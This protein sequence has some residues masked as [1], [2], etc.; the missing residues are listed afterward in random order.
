M[1][2]RKGQLEGSGEMNRE[3]GYRFILSVADKGTSFPMPKDNMCMIIWDPNG[4]LVYDNQ[5]GAAPYTEASFAIEAGAVYIHEGSSEIG[6]AKEAAPTGEGQILSKGLK[7]YPLPLGQEGLWLELPV[8]EQTTGE[9]QLSII[10]M[11]GRIRAE[12]QYQKEGD[13]TKLRWQ[14]ESY[15]WPAGVYMLEIK[16]GSKTYRQKLIK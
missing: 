11:Q 3:E 13:A 1:F 4:L 16:E 10:D 6:I 14:L 8:Y 9:L 7:A 12:K 15:G 5:R 2:R